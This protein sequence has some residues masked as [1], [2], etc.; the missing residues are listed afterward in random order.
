MVL[1]IIQP[2]KE[3]FT[4]ILESY[5]LISSM[6][7]GVETNIIFI[8]GE[9]YE[10]IEYM[11]A[12]D[13][14]KNFKIFSFNIDLLPIDN[15]LLSLE[16]ENCFREIYIDKNLTSISELANAF[17]KLESCFGKVKHRY[18]KGDNSKIFDDLVKEKEKENDL[19]TTEE[20]LGM[21]VLDRSVDFLTTV[22]TNYTYE[23]LIDDYFGINFGTIKIK[24]SIIKDVSKQ[25]RN[26]NT[27]KIITYSLTSY[28]N[29]F[30][31][32][33]GC[34]HYLDAKQ[35]LNNLKD[36]YQNIANQDKSKSKS[37][38]QELERVTNELRTYI[39]EIK[40]PSLVNENILF[41]I[42]NNISETEYLQ[43]IRNE[44]LLLCGEFPSDLH[45]YYEDYI[46]DKKDLNQILKLMAIESITQGGIQG[47]NSIKRDIL[48][49][50]G[51]QNIFL[52]RDLEHLGW[53]KEKTY[54]KNLMVLNYEQL[55]EKLELVKSNYNEQKIEDCSYAMGGY[56]PISLK[57]IEKGVE[58]KW[59]K[60][61]DI[62]KKMP[63]EINFP[64]DESEIVKPNKEVNTIF[65]VFIGGVTY[66]EIAGVRYLNRKF[67]EAYDKSSNKKPTR[68]QLIIITTG[69]L[70]S[71]KIFLNL[72]K[73][74][75]TTYSMKQ[76]YEQTQKP[77]KK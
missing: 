73:D 70:N 3:V 4:I 19:K 66:T 7:K 26:T 38:L 18:I 63:G 62:I 55:C 49:V 72:G 71:K 11:M 59:N 24:E 54:I 1:Y 52:F 43:Y 33:L 40:E 25:I 20:I 6:F 23:G 50:Y 12:N 56:C 77:K 13:L 10:I 47:Y 31:S 74:F 14:I 57:L 60:I 28:G 35:Y 32:Q 69:I 65:L 29:P 5:F 44:Q 64:L 42:I 53:L 48:N 68:K 21:I 34:M 67:K 30:Y 17:V 8:P 76:F 51:Y 36:Y 9:S 15:D 37:S 22:T 58:G 39:S 61:Q 41:Q 16:K 45:L 2:N 46:C 75:K 27:E